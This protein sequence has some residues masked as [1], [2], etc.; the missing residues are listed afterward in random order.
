MTLAI[1]LHLLWVLALGF[2]GY[3]VGWTLLVLVVDLDVPLLAVIGMGAIYLVGIF[4]LG[5]SVGD[6]IGGLTGT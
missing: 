3:G 5:Q 1:I 2:G 4:V 6:Y